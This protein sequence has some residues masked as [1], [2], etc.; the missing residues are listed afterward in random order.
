[1]RL[2][3]FLFTLLVPALL[4]FLAVSA[5][6]SATSAQSAR[7]M[8]FILDASGSMWGR[9]EGRSKIEI[10]KEVLDGLLTSLPAEQPA[11]LMAYGHR[12][13]GD[14]ADIETLVPVAAGQNA[15]LAAAVKG[16]LP[17]GKTPIS[18]ALQQAAN[19]VKSS[20]NAAAIVLVSDGVETCAGDPCAVAKALREAGVDL[21]IHVVGF[22]VSGKDAEQLQCI[23]TEGGGQYF[24]ADNAQDLAS[25]LTAIQAHVAQ[26]EPLPEPEPIPEAPAAPKVETTAGT[27]TKIKLKSVATIQLKPAAWV[28]TPP[29]SWTVVD[30]ES[31]QEVGSGQGES[32]KIKEGTYQIVWRQ[33]EHGSK[34]VNLN[35]TVQ[36]AGGETVDL[37]L[38]TGVR[39]TGPEGL[40]EAYYWL[41]KDDQGKTAAHFW[42]D[43]T[44]L[45][46][47][48]PAG[49]YRLIWRST[50]HGTGEADLGEVSIQT[51]QLLDKVLDT[52][53]TLATPVWLEQPYEA[54]LT[55]TAGVEYRFNELGV[56]PLAPGDY[57]LT[58]RQTEHGHSP[59]SL[60]TVS[61]T[62]GQYTA[63]PVNSGLTFLAGDQPAPYRV[64]ATNTATGEKAE[65]YGSWGPMPLGP[66]TYALDMQE[67]EHG[68][69]P[70]R[71]V[72][73]LPIQAG[74]L[75][76]LE[77]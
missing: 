68:G 12:H 11:G 51:G 29:K 73:E 35:T 40:G 45:A 16:L 2:A 72:D 15:Q 75:L 17:K 61:V 30:A 67:Q 50:E 4:C 65:M 24:T 7:S 49:T 20:E 57:A 63:L 31:G 18:D 71:L 77:L 14:C 34:P 60:G 76:E 52:G 23:A 55:N 64:I 53:V 27:T 56:H 33:V 8:L 70:L 10:A 28:R 66:G 69:D 74:Q 41:L 39:L 54:R 22:D 44:F 47:L 62:A 5:L 38:D 26:N 25:A 36:V 9:V 43:E 6:P 19:S 1:M 21:K 37:P 58:W 48:V 59:L 46:Q 13:K 42:G 3:R 32:I